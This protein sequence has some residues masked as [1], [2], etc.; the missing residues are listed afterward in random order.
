MNMTPLNTATAAGAAAIVAPVVA[1]TAIAL[2]L[3]LT[4]DVQAAIVVAI[5][6]GGHWAG[7]Q[8][9]TFSQQISAYLAAKG[10]AVA[11]AAP[12]V[13]PVAPVA[14]VVAPAAPVTPAAPQ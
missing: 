3:S 10:G 8:I 7:Q 6:A 14:P 1:Q 11:P 4:P 2:H 9:G 5:V 13:A 12:V